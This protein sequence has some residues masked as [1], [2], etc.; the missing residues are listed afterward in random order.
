MAVNQ[1]GCLRALAGRGFLVAGSCAIHS[2]RPHTHNWLTAFCFSESSTPRFH[3]FSPINEASDEPNTVNKVRPRFVAVHWKNQG[4][5]VF[6]PIKTST[7]TWVQSTGSDAPQDHRPTQSTA[8][9]APDNWE[10]MG[11]PWVDCPPVERDSRKHRAKTQT[12]WLHQAT[13]LKTPHKRR[14]SL[15]DAENE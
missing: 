7:S 6:V 5:S 2:A 9:E 13:L 3:V 14:K 1:G 4:L 10:S 12:S 11:C 15:E 8:P